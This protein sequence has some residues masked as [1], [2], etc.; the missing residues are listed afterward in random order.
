MGMLS[1]I[2]PSLLGPGTLDT[3]GR[4]RIVLGS[5]LHAKSAGIYLP[6]ST[7]WLL[8]PPAGSLAS[9]LQLCLLGAGRTGVVEVMLGSYKGMDLHER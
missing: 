7:P 1:G 6:H 4:D 2:P 8:P 5:L 3:Q 9:A